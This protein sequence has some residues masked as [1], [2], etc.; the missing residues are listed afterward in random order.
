MGDLTRS[1]NLG[2]VDRPGTAG[3]SPVHVVEPV[4]LARSAGEHDA[5]VHKRVRPCRVHRRAMAACRE[6]EAAGG[7]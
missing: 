1:P 2:E 5:V 7:G 4:S 3:P 6:S